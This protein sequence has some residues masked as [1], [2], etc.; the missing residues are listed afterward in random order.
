MTRLLDRRVDSTNL[1]FHDF[2]PF[3]QGGIYTNKFFGNRDQTQN[4][5]NFALV[6]LKSLTKF[7]NFQLIQLHYLP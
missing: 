4:H 6:K 5:K 1:Q 2:I 7:S 3:Y